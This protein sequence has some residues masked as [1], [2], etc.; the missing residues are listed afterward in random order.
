MCTNE[1]GGCELVV[2]LAVVFSRSL[3][4]AR[5]VVDSTVWEA[6]LG[7]QSLPA[8]AIDAAVGAATGAAKSRCRRCARVTAVAVAPCWRCH[9]GGRR[10]WRRLS[11]EERGDGRLRRP[12]RP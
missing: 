12:C 6:R 8:L 5:A 1:G 9:R 2:T 11:A 4:L 3:W 7:M 10:G